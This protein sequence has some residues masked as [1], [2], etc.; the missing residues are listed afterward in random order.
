M[1]KHL[2]RKKIFPNNSGFTIIEVII[3]V[4]IIASGFLLLYTVFS[5]HVRQ[6]LLTRN[7]ISVELIAD[8]IIEEIQA[9]PYG[10]PAPD[11]WKSPNLTFAIVQ[12]HKIM[13]TY[14]KEITFDNKSFI[15]EGDDNS[16]MVTVK[17]TW[18][19]GTGI[20]GSGRLRTYKE[21]VPVRREF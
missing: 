12:G 5:L 17:I 20:E 14:K 11:S 21:S 13:I 2:N 1:M 6:S 8:S 4:F 9:H 16:D 3:T 10:E 19:E 18:A 7:R 15:G